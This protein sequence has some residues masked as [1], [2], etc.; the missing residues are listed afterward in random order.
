V[1]FTTTT[2]P[3]VVATNDPGGI[4]TND[5]RLNGYL[6]SA[7]TARTVKVSFAWGTRSGSYSSETAG[8]AMTTAG[9]FYFDLSS[10]TPGTTYYCQAKA[11]G[12]GD[13]VYGVEESFTT[14]QG[15]KVDTVDPGS[16]NQKQHLTVAIWGS[17][18][19]GATKIS[20][21]SEIIV[22]DFTV[23]SSTKITAE[24]AI[25]AD[26]T[27]GL[28][29]VSVTTGWGTAT[30]TD[31]FSVV[32]G[33]GGI[34]SSGALATPGSPSELTTVLAALGLFFGLGYW[35]VRRGTRSGRKSVLA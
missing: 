13:P 25:D 16:G 4:T 5:A 32:S 27:E 11:V 2:T 20:F 1:S 19:D 23:N 35:F 7:G 34:C 21:G 17:S 28:R 18:F 29:G 3:P 33:G 14:G 15:P 8:Q 12:D 26:A 24:I 30:K 31:G 9:A 10:L 6:T 22:E